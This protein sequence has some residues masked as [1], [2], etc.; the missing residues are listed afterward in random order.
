MLLFEKA[1]KF[2]PR[3][4][5]SYLENRV[6][7][8]ILRYSDS[9][10]L[11]KNSYRIVSYSIFFKNLKK[12]KHRIKQSNLYHIKIKDYNFRLK[13]NFFKQI[14]PSSIFFIFIPNKVSSYSTPL[15][16]V[17]DEYYTT[18]PYQEYK[19]D[20]IRS[21]VRVFLKFE[22]ITVYQKFLVIKK[23]SLLKINK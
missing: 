5:G 15:I 10:E 8:N 2:L 20:S 23:I 19:H 12:K 17:K 22:R 16:H 21:L 18:R 14:L 6:E 1:Q 11:Q 4:L 13:T 3:N 9:L 7:E